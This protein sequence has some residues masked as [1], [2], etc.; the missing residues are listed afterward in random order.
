MV[1]H[2]RYKKRP[3]FLWNLSWLVVFFNPFETILFQFGSFP[4][5]RGEHKNI[6]NQH[7]LKKRW[8]LSSS[9]YPQLERQLPF[10][11]RLVH[12]CVTYSFPCVCRFYAPLPP[13]L[14]LASWVG[15]RPNIFPENFR[16]YDLLIIC[17][18]TYIYIHIGWNY[19]APSKSHHQEYSIFRIGLWWFHIPKTNGIFF[20]SVGSKLHWLEEAVLKAHETSEPCEPQTKNGLSCFHGILVVKNR[21][22]YNGVF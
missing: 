5:A 11:G 13:C 21:D 9:W 8:K 15:G 20:Q 22:P 14:W 19:P 2:V 16:L 7:L 6:W 4:Q 3:C 1:G 18:Y 10:A 17:K 12:R